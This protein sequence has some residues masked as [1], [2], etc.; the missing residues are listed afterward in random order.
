MYVESKFESNGWNTNKKHRE[1]T[2]YKNIEHLKKRMRKLGCDFLRTEDVIDLPDQITIPVYVKRPIEYSKLRKDKIV[3]IDGVELVAET[4]LTE[5]L[6]LREI[7]ST[8]NQYK[9]QAFEDL[10][11]ST[12]DGMVVFY[13]FKD[14]L[15]ALLEVCSKCGRLI[16][17]VNG[18][19][20][21]LNSYN[22]SEHA[23]VLV[24]YQ[25]GSMGLNLQKY[26][27]IVYYSPVQWS[28]L[29]QQSVKRIHRIG[30]NR[31]CFYYRFI[32]KNSIEEDIYITL[33]KL[34]DYTDELFIQKFTQ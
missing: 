19:V 8:Y 21:D 24:Q 2:G 10:L 3:T 33:D 32:T 22:K 15:N 11:N 7:C 4:A 23:V 31:T 9:L 27:R 30:Q 20:K 34:Q 5:L 13:N 18:S 14:E 26:N 6:Y 29:F 16:S 28:E 25:S 1:I 12:T 17:Q